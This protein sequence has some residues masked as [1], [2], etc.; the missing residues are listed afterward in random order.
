[1]S[2]II[3]TRNGLQVLRPCLTSL[4]ERTRYPDFEV[5]VVDNGSDDPATL[6]QKVE[7]L[8]WDDLE[9]SPDDLKRSYL[10]REFDVGDFPVT[11]SEEDLLRAAAK[12]GQ[13]VEIG[14]A[15][16]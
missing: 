5:L 8:P 2:V 3:P 11:F 16:V 9:A 10:G 7:A 4:L 12:Y 13:A 6:R 15:H 14:R 1:M